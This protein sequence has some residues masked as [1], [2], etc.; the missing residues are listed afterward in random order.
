MEGHGGVCPSLNA[1]LLCMRPSYIH[2]YLETS[3]SAD[4]LDG[5]PIL[6]AESSRR[7]MQLNNSVACNRVR[8]IAFCPAV[9]VICTG[10]VDVPT[11]TQRR[12]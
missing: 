10:T 3:E 6:G 1:R 12:F 2:V 4:K 11:S 8:T 5:L 9:A 7:Q